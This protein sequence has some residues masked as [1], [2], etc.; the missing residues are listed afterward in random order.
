MG[1]KRRSS[2]KKPPNPPPANSPSRDDRAEP[3]LVVL[4]GQ[5][6]RDYFRVDVDGAPI[7]LPGA[8]FKALVK[9]IVARLN[10]ESGLATIARQTIHRLRT[11]LGERGHELIVLGSGE[12]YCLSISSG[13]MAESV[14]VAPCFFELV[15]RRIVTMEDAELVR[16]ACPGCSLADE[17]EG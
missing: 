9:L 15:G 7:W 12:E 10:T 14:K 2:R 5:R 6:R 8:S 16:K 11:T 3:F 1:K 13:K 17:T 4:T